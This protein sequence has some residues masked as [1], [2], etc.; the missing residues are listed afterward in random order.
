MLQKS[1]L[2]FSWRQKDIVRLAVKKDYQQRWMRF[3]WK[4]Y[5]KKSRFVIWTTLGTT[6]DWNTGHLTVEIIDSYR[7]FIPYWYCVISQ[8]LVTGG[9]GGLIRSSFSPNLQE[10]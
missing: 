5:N 2:K 9:G 6:L 1:G 7:H 10:I 3:S 8:L 4:Y